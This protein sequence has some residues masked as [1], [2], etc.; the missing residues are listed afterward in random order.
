[1]AGALTLGCAGAGGAK[2]APEPLAPEL[3]AQ[4][5]AVELIEQDA[6]RLGNVWVRCTP[7]DARILLEGVLQG[8]CAMLAEAGRGLTV[9]DQR[10]HR[11]EVKHRGFH[12]Y[13]TY[14][15]PGGTRATLEVKLVPLAA[16]EKAP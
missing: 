12:P 15:A 1:M 4:Q 7:A 10:L 11:L 2:Q 14:V 3:P 16:E 5:R 6:G 13:V 8:T 9:T